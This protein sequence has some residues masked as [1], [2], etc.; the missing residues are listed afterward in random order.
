MTKKDQLKVGLFDFFQQSLDEFLRNNPDL[1]LQ[2]LEEQL[3]EQEVE[4]LKL[5][6]EFQKKEKRSQEQILK[7][8]EEVKKWHLRIEQAQ[9]L[10]RM[11]LVKSAQEREAALLREG[12]QIWGQMQASKQQIEKAKELYKQISSKLKEIQA[13]KA[14][15]KKNRANTQSQ[16]S[17]VGNT[18]SQTTTGSNANCDELEQEFRKMEMEQELENLKRKMN[19]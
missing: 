12:N 19:K 11:D 5:I 9:R 7:T 17:W 18:W 4:T 3:K 2:A 14:E 6:S 13:K 16:S 1:E 8:G 10:G 15:L